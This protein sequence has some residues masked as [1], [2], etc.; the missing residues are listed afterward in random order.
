MTDG[1]ADPLVFLPGAS[2]NADFWKPVSDALRHPGRRRFLTWPGFGGAAPDPEVRG[3]DDLVTRVVDSI[4]EPVD[5]LAQSMGGV[6]AIRAALEK[7]R[8]VKHLVLAATS[9]GL[10]VAA[11]GGEDWR[12]AFLAANPQVPRWFIDEHAD[13]TDQLAALDLPVLLLWGNADRISPVA[14]GRR[15]A[16]LLPRAELVVIDG[17][18][19]DLVCDRAGDVAPHIEKHLSR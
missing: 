8:L 2:G 3:I 7:P 9:G 6:I 12:P 11:L 5:L 4:S 19:H 15:L 10:D 13:L 14:V 16:A 17:G 1:L 18:T